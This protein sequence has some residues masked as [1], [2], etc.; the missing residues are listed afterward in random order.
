MQ[1][2]TTQQPISPQETSFEGSSK[3]ENV[4]VS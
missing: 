1:V 3:I 2:D 4:I